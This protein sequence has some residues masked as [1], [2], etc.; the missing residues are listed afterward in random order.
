MDVGGWLRG[1]GLERY[2][3]AFREADVG[4]DVLPDLIDADLK[5]LGVSLGDRKRLLKAAA[6]LRPAAA[7]AVAAGSIP[8][9]EPPSER[10]QVAVLFADLAGY[11][12]L[13]R[14][15]DAEELHD[16]SM[17]SSPSPTA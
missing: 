4:V 16:L 3:Q 7:E 11:T 6:A 17:A 15:L 1:L 2:E 13:A 5:E 14:E 10:R 12:A 8:V 9:E